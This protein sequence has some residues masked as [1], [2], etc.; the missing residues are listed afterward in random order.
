MEIMNT[1]P[2]VRCENC[3]ELEQECN[4][5]YCEECDELLEDCICGEDEDEDEESDG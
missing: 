5:E 1:T 3:E 2:E 4:C